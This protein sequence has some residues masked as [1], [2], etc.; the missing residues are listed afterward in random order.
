MAFLATELRPP[1]ADGGERITRL[2]AEDRGRR[3]SISP[4]A[5]TSRPSLGR[6]W[7]PPRFA[8]VWPSRRSRCRSRSGPSPRGAGCRASARR[9]ATSA[10]RRLSSPRGAFRP[11]DRSAPGSPFST[12]ARWRSPPTRRPL[13]RRSRGARSGRESRGGELMA[14]ALGERRAR[15]PE[16]LDACQW[17][18]ERLLRVA[19]GAGLR[20]AVVV[21]VTP[22]Q[23][24]S[25]REVGIL[26]ETFGPPLGVAWDPGR[27]SPAGGP[28][29]A[30][31]RRQAARARRRR[32]RDARER[33]RPASPPA[34]FRASANAT[35]ASPPSN[36]PPT[37]SASLQA[38]PTP[39]TPRWA[40]RS[41]AYWQHEV[42]AEHE[43]RC[44]SNAG[45]TAAFTSGSS[46]SN[47]C[48]TGGGIGH[49]SSGSG[50]I[51]ARPTATCRSRAVGAGP[52]K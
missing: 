2:A 42:A 36:R 13:R 17:A 8:S 47:A 26:R 4:A 19:D 10:K 27:L 29:S 9:T 50:Q 44:A 24:P 23:S 18:F 14:N 33:R 21:G 34:T 49:C 38:A 25:P 39:P 1:R 41:A 28:R 48:R 45:D 15:A 35:P 20:L 22:W 43:R 31:R 52:R 37:P 7:S 3:G 5:V 51:G 11:P 46:V 30:G 40:R 16:I 12:S 6:R 32:R